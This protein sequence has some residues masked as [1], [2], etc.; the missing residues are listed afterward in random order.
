MQKYLFLLVALLCWL[1]EVQ[2]QK[3]ELGLKAYGNLLSFNRYGFKAY[4]DKDYGFFTLMPPSLALSLRKE[5]SPYVS[6]IEA[7]VHLRNEDLGTEYLEER[8]FSLRY[9]LSSYIG[10][11][12]ARFRI[13]LGGAAR[14]YYYTAETSPLSSAVF[15]RIEQEIGVVIA[16]I[17]RLEYKLGQRL[18]LDMN[19]SMLSTNIGRDKSR[20]ENP[21]LTRRQQELGGYHVIWLQDRLLRLGLEYRL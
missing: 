4:Y 10:P 20:V 1:P 8:A 18:R 2:G 6:E 9:D 11:N 15:P 5:G 21:A 19:L 12:D 7:F 17:P 16:F 3:M 13:R 14:A